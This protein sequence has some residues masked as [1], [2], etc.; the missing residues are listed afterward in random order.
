MKPK[1]IFADIPAKLQDE[2][3]EAVLQTNAL[4][5]E[6]IISRGHATPPGQWYDQD[7][8]EWVLLLAG[9]AALRI[10]GQQELIVLRPGDHTL[11]PARCRHRVEWTDGKTETIWLALHYKS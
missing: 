8:D 6:R 4:L 5:L 9:G 11:L 3:F 7:R 10:D 2:H 1:N